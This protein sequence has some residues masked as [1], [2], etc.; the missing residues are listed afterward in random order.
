MNLA[1]TNQ[2][3][4]EYRA[5][6]VCSALKEEVASERVPGQGDGAVQAVCHLNAYMPFLSTCVQ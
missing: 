1:L 6:W 5:G 3:P 4:A 2:F